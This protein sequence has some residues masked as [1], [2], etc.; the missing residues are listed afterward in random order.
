MSKF[1]IFE[2]I[3]QSDYKIDTK[4]RELEIVMIEVDKL[5]FYSYQSNRF[6][7]LNHSQT[8]FK[9]NV[10]ECKV[11]H[12]VN[13][14][15]FDAESYQKK[16]DGKTY[17][18]DTQLVVFDDVEYILGKLL[19]EHQVQTIKKN[20]Q[21]LFTGGNPSVEQIQKCQKALDYCYNNKAKDQEFHPI[22]VEEFSFESSKS[23]YAN[24]Y[25]I[26]FSKD[27]EK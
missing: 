4:F 21:F 8:R 9:E 2:K 5:K 16:I 22:D 11:G 14:H 1:G 10:G 17:D 3:Y 20:F 27:N 24:W 13:S 6:Y 18:L 15:F 7:P 26:D 25:V 12:L 23:S 19:T